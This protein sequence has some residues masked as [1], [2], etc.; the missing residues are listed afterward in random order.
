MHN[1]WRPWELH[2]ASV[3]TP[4]VHCTTRSVH[5]HQVPVM[6][7]QHCTTM[8]MQ[9]LRLG[10]LINC[11]AQKLGVSYFFFLLMQQQ[12]PSDTLTRGLRT[13]EH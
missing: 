10:N 7:G 11:P 5:R 12:W 2:T 4:Q 3:L 9:Q 8:V 13:Q 6:Y 1:K